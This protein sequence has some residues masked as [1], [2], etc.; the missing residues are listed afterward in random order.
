MQRRLA[1]PLLLAAL[2]TIPAIAIEQSSVSEPWDT[3][4][5]VLSW[6]IW[7]AFLAEAMLMLSVEENRWVWVREHP[8]VQAAVEIRPLA[9][10][11]QLISMS[12]PTTELTSIVSAAVATDRRFRVRSPHASC[13]PRLSPAAYRRS[14]HFASSVRAQSA[15]LGNTR[16]APGA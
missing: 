5:N 13:Q 15:G 11:D 4:A 2:L 12:R 3:L 7:T 16:A 1:A 8:L 6:T 14:R 9:R 10:Y